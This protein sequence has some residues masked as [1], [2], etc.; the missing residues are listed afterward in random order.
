[1]NTL[2]YRLK[3][4]SFVLI[5]FAALYPYNPVWH[6]TVN[7]SS[8]PSLPQIELNQTANIKVVFLGVPSGYIDESEFM[9]SVSKGVNQFA[10]PNTMTW[11]FNVSIFFHEFPGTVMETLSDDAYHFEGVTYYN[12]T[13]LDVL[14][15]QFEGLT[16]PER[17]YLITF[18]CVPDNAINHSWFYVQERPDLFLGRIDYF[19][20]IPFKYW[21]FPP[22]FGGIRRALYFD[23]SDVIE[24]TPVKAIVTDTAIRLFNNGL[25]DM[26]INLLG[27]TDSRM[28]AADTQKYENY[29]VR[30]LWL[31]G[32]SEQLY[33]ERIKEAFED[34]MPWTNWSITVQTRPM[35]AEL[36]DLIES[37]TVELS[38]PLKYSFILANGSRFSIEANRNVIWEVWR[39]SGEYDPISRYLFEH[40]KDYFNLTDLEDKSIIPVVFLQL[41]ND[42]AIGGVAG[43]G[44][45]VSW[46]PYN[47]IIMGYQGGTVTA[48]EES[49]PILLTHKLRHEVGHWVSLSHHSVH[50]ELGYPKVICSMRSI[51]NQ[52]CA[53][54]KDARARMSFI[55][56]YQETLEL[57]SD[58]Q[59][60]IE[61]LRK[62]LEDA[63]QLFYDWEYVKALEA[64]IS[65][66]HK[67]KAPLLSVEIIAN[68]NTLQSG[69]TSNMRVH[70]TDGAS[71]VPNATITLSSDEGGTFS[72][73]IGKTDSNGVFSFIFT[74][75][76][77]INQ[78]ICTITAKASK[79]E[80]LGGQ[81]QTQV[82]VNPLTRGFDLSLASFIVVMV[83]IIV[84]LALILRKRIFK[85]LRACSGEPMA[86]GIMKYHHIKR[87]KTEQ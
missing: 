75:P 52:F 59:A 45:G 83:V 12:I 21:A 4:V 1:M 17:G 87:F 5:V 41:R 86:E 42:T 19:N 37:R 81:G 36:N 84:S 44:P 77:V 74:A 28:I 7:A 73:S 24:K 67:S 6:D 70:V 61:L 39:D 32:T 22:S 54:C 18:M 3:T 46:F 16:I 33:P 43:I 51:T 14:L 40:V 62:E 72:E 20:G 35:E 58:N 2:I 26:F 30:I 9:S 23:I 85:L 63:L 38:K 50:F 53:F 69:E 11:N 68:P 56:Y 55:S 64:I 80:Y 78:T 27:A 82:T 29:E 34:L 48:M 57:L 60:K 76:S 13:L 66:H 65:I 10:Y 71:P 8:V 25:V 15:S 49:G 47:I 31:N 79:A